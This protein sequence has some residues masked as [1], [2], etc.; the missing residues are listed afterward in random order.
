MSD[1]VKPANH[2][3][4]HRG[5]SLHDGIPTEMHYVGDPGEPAFQNGWANSGGTLEN[6][7]FYLLPGYD[8]DEAET[9]GIRG[10]LWIEGSCTG[11]ANGTVVFTLPDG[12]R[13]R[14]EK[15][16]AASDD[17]GNFVVLR[18]LASGDVIRGI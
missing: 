11:G 7:R 3:R 9:Y 17:D 6:M 5:G 13:P 4:D 2:G 1:A 14:K 10:R 8:P 12:Y 16:I 18:V 15:R